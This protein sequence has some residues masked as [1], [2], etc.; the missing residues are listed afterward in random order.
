M[1]FYPPFSGLIPPNVIGSAS[2]ILF[3][4]NCFTNF[5][6]FSAELYRPTGLLLSCTAQVFMVHMCALC[7]GVIEIFNIPHRTA[8]RRIWGL[9][10]IE[11]V[12]SFCHTLCVSMYALIMNKLV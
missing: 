1:L 10:Y 12:E 9:P 8:L 6:T 4:L 5:Y 2:R 3:I 11:P 7:D